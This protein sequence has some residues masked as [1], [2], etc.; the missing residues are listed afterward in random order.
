MTTELIL[1]HC[2]PEKSVTIVTDDLDHTIGAVCSQPDEERVLH[3]VVYNSRK[4]K[5]PEWNY[6][7][8]D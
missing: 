3:P 5:D 4:V 2:D 8:H 6:D 7:I 1:Q